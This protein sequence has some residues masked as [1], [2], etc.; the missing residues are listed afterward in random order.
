MVKSPRA[1]ACS[2]A[3]LGCFQIHFGDPRTAAQITQAWLQKNLDI[4]E[5]EIL[6]RN[7]SASSSLVMLAR[8]PA[9]IT[10]LRVDEQEY[11]ESHM[12]ETLSELGLQPWSVFRSPNGNRLTVRLP[13]LNQRAL[14]PIV[15]RLTTPTVIGFQLVDTTAAGVTT[16][17][18]FH[19]QFR[20]AHPRLA[21]EI[22]LVRSAEP[23][24]GHYLLSDRR[25]ALAALAKQFNAQKLA[26]RSPRVFLENVRNPSTLGPKRV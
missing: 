21:H 17:L 14:R 10:K 3:R 7:R 1:A 6:S 11:W 22:R 19:R 13:K 9:A 15:R 18:A 20:T 25:R 23:K 16:L 24:R 2:P 4:S 26:P 8:R 12:L 5:L